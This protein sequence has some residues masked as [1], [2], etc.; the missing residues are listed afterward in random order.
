MVFSGGTYAVLCVL[1]MYLGASPS[2]SH[3]VLRLTWVVVLTSHTL[4][5]IQATSS[6]FRAPLLLSMQAHD[7]QLCYVGYAFCVCAVRP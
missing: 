7:S 1:P 6:T 5:S 3:G 4:H 2:C